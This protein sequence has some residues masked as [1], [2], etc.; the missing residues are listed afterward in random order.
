[1]KVVQCLGRYTSVFVT[2]LALS[3]GRI[4]FHPNPSSRKLS[5]QDTH[6]SLPLLFHTIL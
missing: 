1:M 3:E 5:T 6:L 4:I 2:L